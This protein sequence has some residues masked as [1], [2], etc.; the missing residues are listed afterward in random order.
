M[1]LVRF[2]YDFRPVDREAALT[3]IRREIAAAQGFGLP[4]R[5][6]VPLTR[7]QGGASMHFEVELQSLDQLETFR[8]RGAGSQDQTE[9]WMRAFSEILTSPPA[10]EIMRI[11]E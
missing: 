11:I 5:L 10:T 6:L 1:F 7:A 8:Q 9:D 3:F 2:S 4:A